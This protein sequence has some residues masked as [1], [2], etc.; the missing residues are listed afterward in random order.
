MKKKIIVVCTIVGLIALVAAVVVPSLYKARQSYSGHPCINN[1]RML[2]GAK[3]QYAIDYDL[4]N[5]ASV[6][7]LNLVEDNNYIKKYPYCWKIKSLQETSLI[8]AT[9]SYELNL[10]GTDP[11]CRFDPKTHRLGGDMMGR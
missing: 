1:L 5:G 9:N 11:V 6:T 4:T 10:I 3:E 2:N 7:F 8:G